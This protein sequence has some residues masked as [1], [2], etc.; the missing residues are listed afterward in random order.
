MSART[1]G[2]RRGLVMALGAVAA[3]VS[4]AGAVPAQGAPLAIGYTPASLAE[5]C[6]SYYRPFAQC[7]DGEEGYVPGTD[8]A[9]VTGSRTNGEIFPSGAIPFVRHFAATAHASTDARVFQAYA[10]LV[11]TAEPD[12]WLPVCCA[13][14]LQPPKAHAFA[15]STEVSRIDSPAFAAG[16]P[17]I[18]RISLAYDGGVRNDTCQTSCY[19]SPGSGTA[20]VGASAVFSVSSTHQEPDGSI[21]QGLSERFDLVATD[22]FGQRRSVVDAV[23]F[24]V[25]FRFGLPFQIVSQLDALVIATGSYPDPGLVVSGSGE[26]D[27]ANTA[28]ITQVQVLDA[29]AQGVADFS[30]TTGSGAPFPTVPEPEPIAAELAAA[31]ALAATRRARAENAKASWPQRARFSQSSGESGAPP[32]RSWPTPSH[33]FVCPTMCWQAVW[34]SRRWRSKGPR[35]A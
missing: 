28:R 19:E 13:S 23:V 15:R 26:A 6:G 17:G 34:M 20:A 24:D 9:F 12:G 30:I 7:V 4:I 2:P 21:A 29:S 8:S 35:S 22:D 11:F 1:N 16:T 32:S 25:P 31:L 5:I 33:A 27:F 10:Y 3:L 18:L 14:S